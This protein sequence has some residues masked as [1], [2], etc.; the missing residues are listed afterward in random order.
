MSDDDQL[1]VHV[2]QPLPMWSVRWLVFGPILGWL[3][4]LQNAWMAW[5]GWW[6]VVGTVIIVAAAVALGY[7]ARWMMRANLIAKMCFG[8]THSVF[9]PV[10]DLGATV[11][12]RPSGHPE[13]PGVVIVDLPPKE[14]T[15][16]H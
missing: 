4:G 6:L 12:I 5:G 3:I 13:V 7:W 16:G 1:V 10:K 11:T 2:H 14:E 8:L 15:N 9:G